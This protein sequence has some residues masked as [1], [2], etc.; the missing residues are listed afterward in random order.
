M[1]NGNVLE[2]S[3]FSKTDT[4]SESDKKD[5]VSASESPD[6]LVVVQKGKCKRNEKR[7]LILSPKVR[8]HE[9]KAIESAKDMENVQSE[10]LKKEISDKVTAAAPATMPTI[11]HVN[12]VMP[13]STFMASNVQTFPMDSNR[14]SIVT[15]PVTGKVQMDITDFSS[16][17]G[18]VR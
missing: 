6:S 10:T 4:E 15:D 14:Q 2:W 11:P 13:Q 3:T 16:L 5:S 1:A 17:M 8:K 9:F 12:P 7:A 18:F